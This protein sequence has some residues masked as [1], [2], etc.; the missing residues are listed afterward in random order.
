MAQI[1]FKTDKGK[2]R[3]ANEDALFVMPKQN[4]FI[5][6]D[7]VG[8][9]NAGEVASRTTVKFIADYIQENQIHPNL[10]QADIKN[11]FSKCMNLANSTIFD[12]ANEPNYKNGMATTAVVLYIHKNIANI[13]NVGDSRAYLIRNDEIHQITEDHTIV[14]QLI[15]DGKLKKEE[16]EAHPLSNMITKAVGAED[17]IAPDFYSFEIK[18]KDIIMLCSDGLYNEVSDKEILEL[19]SRGATMHQTCKSLIDK[20]NENQG[21]DNITVI[22]VKI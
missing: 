11:Y 17:G 20:A 19:I 2:S 1:G 18:K 9:H 10:I 16:A 14:N 15:K 6:A 3:V 5:L 12:L 13:I 22:C 8:G 4:I 21:K 7:G